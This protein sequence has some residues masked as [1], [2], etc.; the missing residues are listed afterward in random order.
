MAK[1]EFCRYSKGVEKRIDELKEKHK[2]LNEKDLKKKIKKIIKDE[3]KQ[4]KNYKAMK[5]KIV[6]YIKHGESLIGNKKAQKKIEE[7]KK[8]KKKKKDKKKS[9]KDAKKEEKKREVE[10]PLTPKIKPSTPK[11]DDKLMSRIGKLEMDDEDTVDEILNVKPKSVRKY[12]IST[13]KDINLKGD[14]LHKKLEEKDKALKTT[15]SNL[16]IAKNYYRKMRDDNVRLTKNLN[17]K[18]PILSI[19]TPENKNIKKDNKILLT[20]STSMTPKNNDIGYHKYCDIFKINS[21]Y[22]NKWYVNS[23]IEYFEKNL[24]KLSKHDA[25]EFKRLIINVDKLLLCIEK[26]MKV[27]RESYK[28]LSDKGHMDQL[29]FAFSLYESLNYS[30][31]KYGKK[32]L[33][34]TLDK[35]IKNNN[36]F[37]RLE[38]ED[39]EFGFGGGKKLNLTKKD[40]KKWKKN[41]LK[42][43][44]TNRAIKKNKGTYNKIEK[45]CQNKKIEKIAKKIKK[46][47][48]QK[49]WRNPPQYEKLCKYWLKN[50]KINPVTKK[51]LNKNQYENY[52]RKCS[53]YLSGKISELYDLKVEYTK[54]YLK[55]LN[56]Q[57]GKKIIKNIIINE[58]TIDSIIFRISYERSDLDL[59]IN[60]IILFLNYLKKVY[61]FNIKEFIKKREDKFLDIIKA[62]NYLQNSTKYSYTYSDFNKYGKFLIKN[63]INLQDKKF[64]ETKIY[65]SPTMEYEKSFPTPKGIKKARKKQLKKA[66]KKGIKKRQKKQK[67]ELGIVGTIMSFF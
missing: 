14:N 16:Q 42:N 35:I 64:T 44:K 60:K 24:E 50:Q 58:D 45:E 1:K 57:Y 36:R 61:N 41:K 20:K 29:K 63:G 56:K 37:N 15:E 4:D 52:K 9:K 21:K 18:R 8:S 7:K 55:K 30:I 53:N 31:S 5:L 54:M 19:S 40:C 23:D 46:Q 66:V 34:N 65:G 62:P 22:S 51:K 48:E 13:P 39:D 26:R 17:K 49:D 25:E 2:D 28:S 43:P 67:V 59:N 32:Y 6:E 12:S 33:I 38:Y 10:K 47:R 27:T 11:K 3:C